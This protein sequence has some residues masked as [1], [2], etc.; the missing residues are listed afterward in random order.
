MSA[1]SFR[2][3]RPNVPRDERTV[4]TYEHVQRESILR[5]YAVARERLRAAVVRAEAADARVEAEFGTVRLGQQ[6]GMRDADQ[7]FRRIR[8]HLERERRRGIDFALSAGLDW[9]RL[10][11][12]E[13][14]N[15]GCIPYW[16]KEI[17]L[18][19]ISFAYQ[20]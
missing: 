10:N 17:A 13:G 6:F 3:F 18:P 15:S 14:K 8:R 20:F 1:D 4:R 5:T 9:S 2:S 7:L 16:P 11:Y 19:Y 12:Y